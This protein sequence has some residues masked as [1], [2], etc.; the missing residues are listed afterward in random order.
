MCLRD[1]VCMQLT[2]NSQRLST[3]IN[4][5][6]MKLRNHI[7]CTCFVKHACQKF[8]VDF[9]LNNR[10]YLIIFLPHVLSSFPSSNK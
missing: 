10:K 1:T 6:A 2:L 9:N 5:E 3:Y 8:V 4:K 7:T